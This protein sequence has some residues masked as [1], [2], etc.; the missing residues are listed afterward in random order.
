MLVIAH[1][2]EIK[3]IFFNKIDF[4]KLILYLLIFAERKIQTSKFTIPE[5]SIIPTTPKLKGNK[6]P[7][8]FVGAPSKNQSKKH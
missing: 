6:F 4:G 3:T 1:A 7:A 8:L 2:N 5:D